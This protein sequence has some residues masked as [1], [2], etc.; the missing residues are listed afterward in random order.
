MHE[1]P[2]HFAAHD[3][4]TFAKLSEIDEEEDPTISIQRFDK[5]AMG[6]FLGLHLVNKYEKDLFMMKKEDA[7]KQQGYKA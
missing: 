4:M 2:L 1:L 3:T 7:H 6:L 5:I